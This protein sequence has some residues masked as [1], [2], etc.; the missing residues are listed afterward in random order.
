M[1]RMTV[2]GVETA[3]RKVLRNA[4]D[5]IRDAEILLGN[6]RFPRAYALAVLACEEVGK[7][8]MLVRAGAA[9][10]LG[11]PFDWKKLDHRLRKHGEKLA[12]IALMDYCLGQTPEDDREFTDGAMRAASRGG[13]PSTIN[14]LKQ[15]A[16]YVNITG[17][18]CTAPCE[19]ISGERAT[20]IVTAARAVVTV[21]ASMEATTL[22]RIAESVRRPRFQEFLRNAKP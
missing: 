21:F 12:L 1:Q 14:T 4:E 9:T 6:G 3:R 13:L 11:R 17:E 19:A 18:A 22:G 2:E 15:A 20:R 8:P 10:T 7:L 5:L 16:L